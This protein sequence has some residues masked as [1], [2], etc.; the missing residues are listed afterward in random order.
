MSSTRWTRR[1]VLKGAGVALS[2]PWLETFETKEGAG[3]DRP[4]FVATCRS[5]GPSARLTA[6]SGGATG[7][8]AST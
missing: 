4:R 7:A 8:G 5:T 1:Q 6:I 3:A 2:V